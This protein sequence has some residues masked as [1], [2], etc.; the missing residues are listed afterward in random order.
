M[1]DQYRNIFRI[2]LRD[3]LFEFFADGFQFRSG[4]KFLGAGVIVNGVN[5]SPLGHIGI[6]DK[7]VYPEYMWP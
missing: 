4:G 3:G 7:G 1:F 2:K 6:A 5:R